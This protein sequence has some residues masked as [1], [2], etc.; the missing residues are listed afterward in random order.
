MKTKLYSYAIVKGK[1]V[2]EGD[3]PTRDEARTALKFWKKHAG[4]VNAK[5]QQAR[6]AVSNLKFVR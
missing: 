5:I 6:Y 3:I 2:L 1:Q 4:Q